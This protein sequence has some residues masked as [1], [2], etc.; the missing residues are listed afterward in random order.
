[1]VKLLR[2][3]QFSFQVSQM[4]A[5]LVVRHQHFRHPLTTDELPTG[6]IEDLTLQEVY[7]ELVS[8]FDSLGNVGATGKGDRI[9][10]KRSA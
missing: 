7:M 8:C 2:L 5:G 10:G 4:V 9:G 1:M 6:L 3:P